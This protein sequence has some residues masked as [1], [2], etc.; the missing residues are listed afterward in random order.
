LAD[1]DCDQ[2]LRDCQRGEAAALERLIAHFQQRV[3]RLA[4]R[5]TGDALLAEEAAAEVFVKLWRKSHQWR[6]DSAASTWIYQLATRT[7][8]D[9]QRS[10]RRWWR[11]NQRAAAFKYEAS[12]ASEPKVRQDEGTALA[13][14]V[15]RALAELSAEDRALVHLYY[16]EELTIAELETILQASGDALKMRLYRVRK[17]LRTVLDAHGI[18][19]EAE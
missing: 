19:Y 18:R 9:I 6:G 13:G 12:E 8:L 11:R 10:Q 17:R 14:R 7:V 1:L 5:M 4:L 16:Y 2:T 15:H 3:F